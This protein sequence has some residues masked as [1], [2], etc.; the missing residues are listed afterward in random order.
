MLTLRQG[1]SSLVVTPE[2]GGGLT[3]WLVGRTAILRRASP[4]ASAWGDSHA[5]GCFPLLPFANR[6]G[7]ARFAWLGRNYALERNFGD[8]PHAIHGVGRGRCWTVAEVGVGSVTL[9]LDHPGDGSWPFAFAAELGYGLSGSGVTV[10]MRLTNRHDTP[11]PAGLGLHP[12]FPKARD[13]A[14]RFQAAGFWTNGPDSLPLHH[15]V[16]PAGWGAGEARFVEGAQLDNCFTGSSGTADI[17]AG[18]ASLRIEASAVFRHLQVFTPAWGDFFCVEPVS[19]VPNALNRLDLPLDQ[20]MHVLQP[21]ETLA[22][23]IRLFLAG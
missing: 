1:T 23:T 17:L 5:M 8:S 20:A 16:P 6:M 19:H 11:A 7:G 3:G 12:Y 9:T 15:G 13:A 14:L 18:P 21:G 10:T 2:Y 22:G 4:A